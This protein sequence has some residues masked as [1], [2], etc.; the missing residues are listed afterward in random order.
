MLRN[1]N[2]NTSYLGPIFCYNRIVRSYRQFDYVVFNLVQSNHCPMSLPYIVSRFKSF[3]DS[4]FFQVADSLEK[5]I[6]EDAQL[7]TR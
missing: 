7:Y 3:G 4:T 1:L 6:K 5:I 2:E